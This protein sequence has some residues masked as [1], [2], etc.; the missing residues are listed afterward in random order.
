M[1]FILTIIHDAFIP[2]IVLAGGFTTICQ[3]VGAGCGP[4]TPSAIVSSQGKIAAFLVAVIA[5]LS[6]LFVVWGGALMIV[7]GGDESK[8]NQG[9]MSIIY[10]LLGFAIALGAQVLV[11]FVVSTAGEGAS[12]KDPI[13]GLIGVAVDAMLDLFN[14]VFFAMVVYA[15]FRLVWGRGKSEESDKVQTMLIWAIIGG[16]VIN[17]A[18]G[19]VKSV[20]NLGI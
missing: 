10:A 14:V 13:L 12:A 7:S 6:V 4:A 9:R 19:L 8:I 5:A 18:S 1:E 20:L 15:G 17:V 2:P 16:I 3:Y 11:G